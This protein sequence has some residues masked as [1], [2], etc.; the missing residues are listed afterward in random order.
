MRNEKGIND[1]F[2]ECYMPNQT[3]VSPQQFD[4]A[5][6]Q[7]CKNLECI[8]AGWAESAWVQRMSTQVDRLL[9]NPNFA[10]ERD[11]RFRHV[12]EHDF[13][14][15]L[16]EAIRVE[17][18]DQ[19]NDWSIPTNQDVQDLM[20]G[21]GMITHELSN[22]ISSNKESSTT[23]EEN[24]QQNKPQLYPQNNPPKEPN[25]SEGFSENSET[26]DPK[27]E[28]Q[29]IKQQSQ[30]PFINTPFP[31]EG[32]SLGGS[33]SEEIDTDKVQKP[34]NFVGDAW[35]APEMKTKP[36]NLVKKGARIQM[37]GQPKKE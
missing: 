20:V 33:A 22:D 8:R 34:A 27:S 7:V 12:R 6:C 24:N 13:P 29:S 16:Q 3:K 32:V 5:F 25:I 15:L 10:D 2:Q 17:I 21:K 30:N 1:F 26:S 31:K 4:E 23:S 19:K 18:I 37:G 11:P 35:T 36:K 28:I 9:D 14:S